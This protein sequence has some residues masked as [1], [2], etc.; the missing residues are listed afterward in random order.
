[1]MLLVVLA[2]LLQAIAGPLPCPAGCP[3]LSVSDQEQVVRIAASE[4][5]PW[6]SIRRPGMLGGMVWVLLRPD[7][8]AARIRRGRYLEMC[9]WKC[10][11]PPRRLDPSAS[12]VWDFDP[13]LPQSRG[14]YAQVVG[15]GRDADDIR[16]STDLNRPFVYDGDFTDEELISL[17]DF[18]RTSPRVP[19]ESSEPVQGASPIARISREPQVPTA[20]N[21][22]IVLPD[23][24]HQVVVLSRPDGDWVVSHTTRFAY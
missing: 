18:I 16:G 6:I 19:G 12:R 5:P 8:S 20:L 7:T 3:D 23:L 1:M 24:S 14:K 9:A 17:V 2:Q 10:A 15:P 22:M 13:T 4:G 21:V 11:E